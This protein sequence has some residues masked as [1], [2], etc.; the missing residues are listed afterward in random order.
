MIAAPWSEQ[1]FSP[2]NKNSDRPCELCRAIIP[3]RRKLC[4]GC[5]VRIRRFRLKFAAVQLLGGV[6]G[7]CGWTGDPAGYVF[8]HRQ[9]EEKSDTVAKLIQMNSSWPTV[10]AE[11]LKCDLWCAR[12]HSIHHFGGDLDDSRFMSLVA[13][14]MGEP[15]T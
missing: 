9:P 4:A 1:R 14:Y 12:C 15:L 3:G 10:K 2:L 8:H 7:C 11:A 6:A 13:R 5:V